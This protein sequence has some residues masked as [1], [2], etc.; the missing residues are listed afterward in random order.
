MRPILAALILLPLAACAPVDLAD[1]DP[2]QRYAVQVESRDAVARLTQ[3]LSATDRAA[4]ADLAGEFR[5]RS[6]GPVTLLAPSPAEA[7]KVAEILTGAGIPR[8][9]LRFATGAGLEVR[10]PVWTAQVP[11]CG[12]WPDRINP[13]WRNETTSHYGC[14]VTR[15]MGLMLSNPADLVRARELSGR[16]G[17]RAVDVLT[18]YGQGKATGAAP[19]A[20]TATKGVSR[21]GK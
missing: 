4:L 7:E 12:Q 19:E 2:H 9:S 13:D 17:E 8:A 11:E 21:M 18:K 20:D 1:H 3:P 14:A 5:R 16:D 6:A 15:N 10:V